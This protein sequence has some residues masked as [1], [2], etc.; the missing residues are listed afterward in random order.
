M[1]H[2]FEGACKSRWEG[3][4]GGLRVGRVPVHFF[5][6]SHHLLSGQV[7]STNRVPIQT[8]KCQ[9][10]DSTTATG[11]NKKA[12]SFMA[13][14]ASAPDVQATGLT[15]CTY[16]ANVLSVLMPVKAPVH[17]QHHHYQH[18]PAWQCPH[19]QHSHQPH[20]HAHDPTCILQSCHW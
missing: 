8:P 2:G 1:L 5:H 13:P 15:R 16:C 12:S 3:W 7:R 19:P 10:N 4:D 6:P 9:P 11:S 14:D 20:Q 18:H 17:Y